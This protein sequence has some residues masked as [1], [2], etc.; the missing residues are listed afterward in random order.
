MYGIRYIRLSNYLGG[1]MRHIHIVAALIAV[2]AAPAAHAVEPCAALTKFSMPGHKVIIRKAEEL[3]AGTL[4]PNPNG[5][6]GPPQSFPAHCRVDG[7]IDERTG[8]DGKSYG[9]GFAVALPA[10]WNGRFLFQG[11]GGLNGS[12]QPPL[13]AQYAGEQSALARGFAVASTDSGHQGAVFDGS[14]LQDQQATLNFLYQAV[15]EV[16][17]VAKQII[18]QHYRKANDRAYF[19]GCSTGGREAMM[20]SQRFPGYFDGIVAGAPAMRTSFSNLGLRHAATALNAVA[21]ASAN[22]RP[23]TR[24]A[25]S[26]ADRRTDHRRSSR[27]PAMRSTA[28]GTASSS[29]RTSAA[30]IPAHSPART[31][32]KMAAS[33]CRR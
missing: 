20:M 17:V 33:H 9:I 19:V 22:G 24:A 2:A 15:G 1:T 30:S 8:R 25:L 31:A 14:F 23:E 6:P 29:R 12:V 21:P 28:T 4:P 27:S 18:A 13:G 11:G 10:S 5:P 16:T 7:V 32:R 3:P 26:E